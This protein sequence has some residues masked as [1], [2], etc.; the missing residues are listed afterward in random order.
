MRGKLNHSREASKGYQ[1]TFNNF[2]TQPI[3]YEEQYG[4]NGLVECEINTE[5][6]LSDKIWSALVPIINT[7]VV[8][9]TDLLKLFSGKPL[10]KKFLSPMQ[11]KSELINAYLD[12]SPQTF[13]IQHP[14]NNVNTQEI[15]QLI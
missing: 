8:D 3:F 10:H 2:L 13:I 14:I 6:N 12:I 15:K 7:S 9:I 5:T 4:C 11:Q 1:A